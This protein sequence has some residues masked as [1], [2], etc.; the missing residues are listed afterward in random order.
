MVRKITGRTK[1]PLLHL[2]DHQGHIISDK[3]DMANEIGSSFEKNSS[4]ANYSDDFKRIKDQ[5][6]RKPL[7]FKTKEIL[8]YNKRFRLR[9]LK[10]S[11]KRS[12][13]STPGPDNIHYRILKNMP[14]ETLTILLNIINDHWDSQ[15]FPESWREAIVLPIPKPGKDHQ[16]STNFRPIALTSCIC[17]TV[18]RM[19]NE[20]LIHYLEKNK[21]LTK[22]Q[23]GF[24]SERSTLDL[25][26]L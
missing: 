23:A 1:S 26:L 6:E 13:D 5:E 10:R 22:F 20:R 19:V 24:R 17:K 11:I 21:I 8:P 2:K 16:N 18:E 4:S 9:D 15:S 25:P 14:N 12:K 7:N 3:M